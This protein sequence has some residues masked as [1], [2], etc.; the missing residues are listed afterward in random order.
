MSDIPYTTPTPEEDR[1]YEEAFVARYNA[2]RA[3]GMDRQRSGIQAHE[4]AEQT[5]ATLRAAREA[6]TLTCG[7]LVATLTPVGPR[8]GAP[9]GVRVRISGPATAWER[10]LPAD[11]AEAYA[12]KQIDFELTTDSVHTA[13]LAFAPKVSTPRQ[14][15]RYWGHGLAG[16]AAS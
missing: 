7:E 6:K 11:V 14:N 9:A 5:V 15:G 10:V 3:E 13:G 12:R 16:K 8:P 1:I 2:C 4:A